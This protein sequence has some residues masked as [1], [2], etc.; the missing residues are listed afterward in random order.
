MRWLRQR[1]Q[2][3]AEARDREWCA[4]QPWYAR[5]HV[6]YMAEHTQ[7]PSIPKARKNGWEAV[8]RYFWGYM[9]TAHFTKAAVPAADSWKGGKSFHEYVGQC[10]DRQRA[11][12]DGPLQVAAIR[13]RPPHYRSLPLTTTHH[14]SLPLTTTH[15]HSPPLTTT[16]CHPLP[17]TTTHSLPLTTTLGVRIYFDSKPK[18]F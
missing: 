2:A 6:L 13:S 17:L 12:S 3:C 14:H 9:D 1:A 15:Y 18:V 16:H 7:E 11:D 8:D 5:A 10:A 4:D